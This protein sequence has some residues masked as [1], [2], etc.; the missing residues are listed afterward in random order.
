MP[1]KDGLSA[2]KEIIKDNPGTKVV[3]CSAI[4]QQAMVIESIQIDA[5]DLIVKPFIPDS[6]LESI[7]KVLGK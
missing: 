4:G 1:Q 5:K 2:L 6:V 3:M 7:G